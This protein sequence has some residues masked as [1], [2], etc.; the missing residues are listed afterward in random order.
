MKNQTDIT[1]ILDRSG[2]MESVRADIIGGFNNFLTTQKATNQDINCSLVQFDHEYQL[3]Y[4][5]IPATVAPLLKYQTYEPRGSTALYDALGQTV[6]ETGER[7]ASLKGEFRPN[8][9]V[10]VV[11][12]D[13]EE[14]A[15]KKY[16]STEL[17]HM[18]K[19]QREVYKWEF[20]FIGANQDAI[21]E[22][23]KAGISKL[24]AMTIAPTSQGYS[25]A[26]TSAALNVSQYAAGA[27]CDTSFSS[28]QQAIAKSQV[29]LFNQTKGN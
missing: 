19:H 28:A 11:L 26:F 5:T 29:D 24:S 9:V 14:N 21:L 18:I 2:S 12:T 6:K 15:S 17:S 13:G 7:L 25:H 23:D 1:F 27:V 22:A 20:I 8:K 16:G 4:F 10:I 3:V